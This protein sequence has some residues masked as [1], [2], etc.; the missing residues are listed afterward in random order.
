MQSAKKRFNIY[1]LSV[2]GM[3]AAVCYVATYIRVEIPTG[4]DR[5]M[6]HFGNIFCLLSG[7]LFGGV[8]GGLSAGIG[9]SV[10][11][12]TNNWVSS[13]PTT[14]VNKFAMAFVCGK[15]AYMKGRNGQSFTYS[16]IG[17][18]SGSLTYI[19]LYL[20]KSYVELIMLGNAHDV[21]MIAI[22]EKAIVSFINGTAAVVVAMILAPM[23]RAALKSAGLY[24]KLDAK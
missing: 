23:L 22:V 21:V 10:F 20:I 15:I 24:R 1:S 6:I 3:M 13:A 5:S 4:I 9:S 11:D 14:L 19:A 8:K 12:L 2:I 18:I 16:L 7:L 17:C